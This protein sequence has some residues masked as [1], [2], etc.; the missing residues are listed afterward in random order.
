MTT[1]LDGLRVVDFT[2]GL[3][4]AITTMV[5]ADNGAEVIKVEPPQGD[6]QRPMPSFAQWHRGKQSAS[7]RPEGCHWRGA[8]PRSWPLQSDVVVQNWRPNVAERLG[9]GYEQLAG[10]HAGLVYCA[11][12]GFGPKGPLAHLRG[13]DA[14]VGA[15]AGLLAYQ[16]R[17]RYS[18]IAGGSFSAAQGGAAG[19]PG[20]P[21][22]RPTAP[23]WARRSRQ[24]WYRG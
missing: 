6:P 19:H 20:R 24:A 14:V 21:L 7:R 11:I 1:A 12:T 2:W 9:L 17:P 5:L 13:Y 22:R 18:A 10:E 15:K 3:A 4:G 16:D 8:G 23:A